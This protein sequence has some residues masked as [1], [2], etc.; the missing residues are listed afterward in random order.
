LNAN[1]FSKKKPTPPPL[2]ITH[3]SHHQL[4]MAHSL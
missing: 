1:Y 2:P 4:A 3:T